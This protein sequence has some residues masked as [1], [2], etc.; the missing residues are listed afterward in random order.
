MIISEP[1]E[2]A[3]HPSPTDTDTH[4]PQRKKT[5]CCGE[6]KDTNKETQQHTDTLAKTKTQC[7][8]ENKGHK[9]KQRDTATQIYWQNKDTV[10]WQVQQHKD[11]TLQIHSDTQLRF[12][13]NCGIT[14]Y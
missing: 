12:H 8:G 6:N 9:L 1:R 3:R 5:Q 13:S 14:T 11:M 4:G 2:R 7:C 10:M